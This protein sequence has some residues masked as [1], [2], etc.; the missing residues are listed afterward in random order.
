MNK[1]EIG[2]RTLLRV[3]S[4]LAD[5]DKWLYVPF[6][7][8]GRV[9]LLYEEEDGRLFR[10]Q[11][12]TAWLEKGCLVFPTTSIDS[13]SVKGRTLRRGYRGEA[14]FFGV[15]SPALNRVYLVPVGDVPVGQARLRLTPPKNNQKTRIRW[16]ADY[17]IGAVAQLGEYQA[18][19][20]GV[21]GSIPV[22]STL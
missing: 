8:H 12:K 6:G 18:G 10:V 9:D 14:D 7:D 19:S 2:H 11:C 1:S 13:R 20:L 16:A 17:E 15:Y 4:A 3:M 21:T 22:G 5:L